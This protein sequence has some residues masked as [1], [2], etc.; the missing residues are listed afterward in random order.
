MNELIANIKREEGFRSMPY[1][2]SLG[3]LTIGYGTKLGLDEEEAEL[4]LRHRLKYFID[5]V[6]FR[7]REYDINDEA[8]KIL[9]EM[10]YQ[11]GT[12]GLMKFKHM[13]KSIDGKDYILASKEGLDSLWAKQTPDRAKR[14]MDRLKRLDK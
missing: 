9:Y 11:L 7:L 14:L 4:I 12:D 8:M 5:K 6:N 2:D 10:A 3:I 13:L 1:K